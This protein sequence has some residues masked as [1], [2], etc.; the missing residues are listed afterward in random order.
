MLGNS[1]ITRSV[2]QIHC[3]VEECSNNAQDQCT[4]LHTEIPWPAL[5]K[6]Y[7][8]YTSYP[9][10][11]RFNYSWGKSLNW[12]FENSLVNFYVQQRL[13]TNALHKFLDSFFIKKKKVILSGFQTAFQKLIEGNKGFLCEALIQQK[14]KDEGALSKQTETLYQC[15]SSSSWTFQ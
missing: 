9:W 6:N 8:T 3:L 5:K 10:R 7:C 11:F 2:W 15:S 12:D 14:L 13:R 4:R 1:L